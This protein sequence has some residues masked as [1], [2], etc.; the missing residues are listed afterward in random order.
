MRDGAAGPSVTTREHLVHRLDAGVPLESGALV[1]PASVVFRGLSVMDLQ[2]GARVVVI[3]AGTLGI[4]HGAP[5]PA[6]VAGVGHGDGSPPRT[7]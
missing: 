2:P 3:G 4:A 5:R 6:V 7:G 1:E